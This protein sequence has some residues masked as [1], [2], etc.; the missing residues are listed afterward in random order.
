MIAISR[1]SEFILVTGVLQ[2]VENLIRRNKDEQ[3]SEYN[4][5]S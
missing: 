3:I 5:L 4:A 2:L 1:H